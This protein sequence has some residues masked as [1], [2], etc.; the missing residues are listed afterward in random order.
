MNKTGKEPS[1]PPAPEPA[2][3]VSAT[4]TPTNNESRNSRRGNRRGN[5]R[6]GNESGT[7]GLEQ[8]YFKGETP[9]LNAVLRLI[10]ERLDQG[11]PFDKFQDVLK[12][13]HKAE[14]IVEMVTDLNDPFT[15]S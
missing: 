11:V 3:P 9:E 14:N 7:S 10:T 15:K 12:N 1:K 13:F 8:K 5:L 2:T 4:S 6:R